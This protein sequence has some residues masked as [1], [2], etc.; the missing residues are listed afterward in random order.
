MILF[1]FIVVLLIIV[2]TKVIEANENT[3][4]DHLSNYLQ[5][6]LS[7]YKVY[8]IATDFHRLSPL[9]NKIVRRTN[10]QLESSNVDIDG[11]VK[12]IESVESMDTDQFYSH[13]MV[14]AS[15]KVNSLSM[16]IIEL[17]FGE[18]IQDAIRPMLTYLHYSNPYNRGKYLIN[19]ITNDAVNLERILKR[20][21]S[22]R[23]LD[24]TVIQWIRLNQTEQKNLDK[25]Q[26]VD[27]EVFVHSFNPFNHT[28]HKEILSANTQIFPDKTKNFHGFTLNWYLNHFD[29]LPSKDT[30]LALALWYAEESLINMLMDAMNCSKQLSVP[31]GYYEQTSAMG[32]TN[33]IKSIGEIDFFLPF[34]HIRFIIS[35]KK[36]NEW[37][38]TYYEVLYFIR[39]PISATYDFHIMRVKEY[40]TEISVAAILSFGGLFFTAFIFTIW[41]IFLGFKKPN[42]SFLNILTVQMGGSIDDGRPMKLSEKIF[43]MS[44][45]IATFIVVTLGSDYM[46][47]IYVLYQKLPE[48]SRIQNLID[49]DLDLVM[50]AE[51]YEYLQFYLENSNIQDILHRIRPQN[52]S[53]GYH[54]F[55]QKPSSKSSILDESINLCLT[56]SGI[57]QHIIPSNDRLQIDHIQDPVMSS[58][59]YLQLGNPS[60]IIKK[61][62]EKLITRFSGFG[63]LNFWQ[64]LAKRSQEQY[65]IVEYDKTTNIK[66]D[67]SGVVPLQTQMLPIFAVG[68]TISIISLIAE[69]I[70]KLYIEGTRFGN[71]VSAFYKSLQHAEP[72]RSTMRIHHP[73]ATEGV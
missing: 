33:Y 20:V 18:K 1:H 9:A 27:Y 72:R 69:Y 38:A 16:L 73:F 19:L 26:N 70:W 45:Y 49:S 55:C 35:P 32:P 37:E 6:N 57:K 36:T 68:C 21:W 71:A 50:V 58:M 7:V 67:D 43:Q 65:Y 4:I 5:Y 30:R 61:P 47:Q 24:F 10:Q 12:V 39:F 44:I 41:A 59:P 60:P 14:C 46:F 15:E 11:M 56:Y 63:L 54:T 34:Y 3:S 64:A 25:T 28:F 13:G 62:L 31:S 17:E 8:V 2:H 40:R 66:S 42:W 52:L 22:K 29:D 53:Q 23:F 48:I 51:D